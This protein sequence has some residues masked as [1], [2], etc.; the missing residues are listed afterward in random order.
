MVATMA[1]IDILSKA[2]DRELKF[3]ED[4]APACPDPCDGGCIGDHCIWCAAQQ[5]RGYLREAGILS[6][7]S[8]KAG[9]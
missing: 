1:D 5:L 4:K 2:I 6:A 9:G 7:R 3:I 8:G